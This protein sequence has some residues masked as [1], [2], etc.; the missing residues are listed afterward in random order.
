MVGFG[1]TYRLVFKLHPN[2]S[3]EEMLIDESKKPYHQP[4]RLEALSPTL[5]LACQVNDFG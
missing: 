4:V 5:A 3:V 1:T 2:T